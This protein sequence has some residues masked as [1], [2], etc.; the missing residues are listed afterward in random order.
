[1][2]PAIQAITPALWLS[3]S[4]RRQGRRAAGV[5]YAAVQGDGL[6]AQAEAIKAATDANVVGMTVDTTGM[7][8]GVY[9]LV[10]KFFPQCAA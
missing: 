3:P 10:Q 5:A 1:M 6:E 7:S 2:T 4:P 9:Q 8:Q